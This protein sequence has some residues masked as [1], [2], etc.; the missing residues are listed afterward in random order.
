M[1]LPDSSSEAPNYRDHR[2]YQQCLW[3]HS[4][5]LPTA[6]LVHRTWARREWDAPSKAC[7]LLTSTPLLSSRM[8]N[9]SL[10]QDVE[11]VSFS[12]CRMTLNNNG[13]SIQFWIIFRDHIYINNHSSMQKGFQELNR[14]LPRYSVA[15]W[16]GLSR[17]NLLFNVCTL[18]KNPLITLPA[19]Y[20]G[21]KNG[22]L[23]PR[24]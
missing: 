20:F 15:M 1:L 14:S 7:F 23:C 17:P 6:Q 9:E 10:I 2:A 13:S 16:T 12:G 18:G 3:W 21:D 22:K 5:V 24:L 4:V 11:W 8:Y 19:L